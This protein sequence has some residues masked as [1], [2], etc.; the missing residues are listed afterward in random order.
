M[1][2]FGYIQVIRRCNQNCRFCASPDNG[3]E[4]S[5]EKARKQLLRLSERG[6]DGV[7]L[8][9]G[10]PT[11]SES[12]PEIIR[13]ANELNL[14][15]RIVT[16]GQRLADRA[17][18]LTL[19]DAG[20]RH[21][22]LSVHSHRAAVQAFLTGNRE[23]L[24]NIVRFLF[25]TRNLPLRVDISQTICRQNMDHLHEA[26]G[27]ICEKFPFVRHISWTYL[28]PCMERV[29]MHP[30]VLPSYRETEVSLRAAMDYL[31]RSGRSFRVEKVPL[32]YMGPYARFSTETRKIVKKERLAGEF[33]DER[34]AFEQNVWYYAKPLICKACSLETICAGIWQ[35]ETVYR[36]DEA[37]P[38][39]TDPKT[40]IRE[41]WE[42]E[43][44]A[45]TTGEARSR[46]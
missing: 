37:R 13:Y 3:R 12:L 16:N 42:E 25:H 8:T 43:T 22:N 38:M 28:D 39:H 10:E 14:P 5:L 6:Y 19:M 18:L 34:T 23:S 36:S 33:L 31:I 2:D 20:L 7:V 15:A 40:I 29:A 4:L 26:V 35:V 44:A 21:V 32:C 9:G 1:A 30:E 41:I 24:A 46:S 45:G 17:Y 11:L 27:W